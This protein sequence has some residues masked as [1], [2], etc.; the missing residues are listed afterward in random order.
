MKL[1]SFFDLL[2]VCVVNNCG[3]IELGMKEMENKKK[4]NNGLSGEL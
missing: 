3:K 4:K 2:T 1:N